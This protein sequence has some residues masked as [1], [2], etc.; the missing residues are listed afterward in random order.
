[1]AYTP[2]QQKPVSGINYTPIV[3]KP[4]TVYTPLSQKIEQGIVAVPPVLSKLGEAPVSKTKFGVIDSIARAIT[5]T[6]TLGIPKAIATGARA[7]SENISEF[8]RGKE[9]G[10]T[11]IL[12]NLVVKPVEKSSKRI[13]ELLDTSQRA[14]AEPLFDEKKGLSSVNEYAYT[15]TGGAVSMAEAVGIALLTKST[16]AS[17]AF[18]SA[19]EA[20][21]EYNLAREKEVNPQ[22]ALRTAALSGAGTF[23][24]EKIG[25]D[26]LFGLKG[27]GVLK[28]AFKS[29][30]FETAQEEVQTVWQNTVRKYG[31]DKA[32]PIFEGLWETAVATSLPSFVVGLILPGVNVKTHDHFIKEIQDKT[33]VDKTQAERMARSMGATVFDARKEFERY[34]K[35]SAAARARGETTV[36]KPGQPPPLGLSLEEVVPIPEEKHEES[37]IQRFN[38]GAFTLKDFIADQELPE[39]L[40]QYADVPVKMMPSKE[41]VKIDSEKQKVI[42][43]GGYFVPE[44]NTIYIN[45]RP[46]PIDDA[47]P[48]SQFEK[49]LRHEVQHKIDVAT[50][51]TSSEESAIAGEKRI[52]KETDKQRLLRQARGMDS[53]KLKQIA[54]DIKRSDITA[55]QIKDIE[56]QVSETE[57]ILE[58]D[59][60]AELRKYSPTRGE[61]AGTLPEVTGKGENVFS[62]RGDDIAN[63]LGFEDSEAA[64]KAFDKYQETR[65]EVKEIRRTLTELRK[66][67]AA[68]R[69]GEKLMSLARGDRR[70]AYRAVRE[71]FDLT[72]SELSKIRRGRD[73]MAM[74]Q[75]EFDAFIT[76]AEL[77]AEESSEKRQAR[78]ELQATIQEKELKKWENVQ[79]AMHLPQISQMTIEQMDQLNEVLSK[80]KRGDEFLTVR[81]LETI[82]RTELEGLRTVREV[83]EHLAKKYNLT[84]EQLPG[85]KPHPWMYDTQLA[86]QHP[87]YDL[88]VNKYNVSYLNAQSRIIELEKQNSELIKKARESRQRTV[89]EK[90]IPTDEK[91]VKW[92]EASEDERTTL[93]KDMT[94][95]E[96]TAAEKM[97][98]VFREY[99]DWLVRRSIEEKF[100]SRF[101]NKYFPHVRRGFLE[102]WKEDGFMKAFKESFDQ[103][104][105]E[106]RMM[107]ILDEKTGDVL[108]YEKWVGFSQFRSGALVP[109][110]NA[111][112]AFKSYIT[113]LEKARQ[114]DEFIPEVMTYV[115]SLSPREMTDRGLEINDSLQRFVKTWINSKKGRVQKQIVKPGGKMDWA[116][117]MGVSLT[118][119]VD[120]G[121]NVPVGIANIFGEQSGNL[122]MLGPKKYAAGLARLSTRKGRR[123]THKYENFVGRSF[124]D[125]LTEASNDVGDQLLSGIFGV[126]GAASRKGNQV[127]L[128][129][130]MTSEEY[131]AET[132]STEKL[133]ALRKA[134]GKYRVV[135]GAESV[136]GK[137]AEAAVGGQYKKWA[138]PILVSTRDNLISLSKTV[139]NR[140]VKAALS[141]EEGSQLFYSTILG[142]VVALSLMG[143]YNELDDDEDRNFIEEII[144]KSIRDALSM[145]GVLS[146][147]FI[148]SFAAP[149]LSSFLVDLSESI[150]SILFMEKYKTTGELKGLQQLERTVTPKVLKQILGE[151]EQEEPTKTQTPKQVG[152]PKLPK[153][154]ALP[155]LPSLPKL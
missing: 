43:R 140:G 60:V 33:G 134:Q 71:A 15:I 87:L 104:R 146:P 93:E 90:L 12:K 142:S 141:S 97:D 78:S 61:Y 73:I 102:A 144:Y 127:F 81:Q 76:Q 19:I 84:P 58:S 49:T 151:L 95:E 106:E 48:Q 86:R 96:I 132:I 118:R 63:E 64:R 89:G 135:T 4:K 8:E 52:A 31:I 10:F 18:L 17:A 36:R 67:R 40:S 154:P 99:Y 117:R 125:T 80:Y 149:R 30:L 9:G 85:I 110:K 130:N 57:S 24:L 6:V 25:L 112:S 114:F 22:K 72:E 120:L 94:K 66:T 75:D 44:E 50:K 137:S 39:N 3:A 109:T 56:L 128:L 35:E 150:N 145:I 29:S 147:D 101:E 91:V 74:T 27:G 59:P 53:E 16:S 138:I 98:E 47:T 21:D 105:Q 115:H 23:L 116:L 107:T 126:F 133:G 129:G 62:Q 143:Y 139:R 124:F 13:I 121:L 79:E 88:L 41:F 103:F 26:Y 123:I 2:I 152:L 28:N 108:P 131:D 46:L 42:F 54:V 34:M 148:G 20:S 77:L 55:E 5:N 7:A 69:K 155:R 82:D 51:G 119:M 1:M 45:P 38:D 83:N 14:L 100:S 92:I 32:Q 65:R 122:T 136:F 70:T 153:L 37:T 68:A 11:S 111:A 113:A